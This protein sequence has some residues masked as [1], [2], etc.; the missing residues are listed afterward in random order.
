MQTSQLAENTWVHVAVTLGNGTAKL[1]V[2][3]VE[4]AS[5][6][7][8]IKPSDFKPTLNYIGKSQFSDPLLNG[9]LDEFR[10][11]DHVLSADEILQLANNTAPQ[12][13]NSLLAYLLD[14]AAVL[15]FKLYTESSWQAVAAAVENRKSLGDQCQS[16]CHRRFG[17]TAAECA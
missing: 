6:N 7:V 15:D 8:S 14:K 3:G 11:Y 5:A 13:D 10:I 9:M 12:G 1:Y 17:R 16:S 4:Q 2:N